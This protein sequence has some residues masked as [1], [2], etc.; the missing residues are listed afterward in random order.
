MKSDK[1]VLSPIIHS[2]HVLL[3][4]V[5]GIFIIIASCPGAYASNDKVSR[6][7]SDVLSR[8]GQATAEIAESVRPAVVNI[9]TMRTVKM[10]GGG[11]FS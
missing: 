10:Q 7:P 1:N 8:I 6:Q 3:S 5:I 9:S 2:I 11:S 4:A